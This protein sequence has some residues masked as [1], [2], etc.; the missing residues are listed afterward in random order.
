MKNISS[1]SIKNPIPIILLF[2]LLTIAG[3]LSFISMRINNNPDIDFP[4]VAVTAAPPRRGA[5]RDGDPGHPA[6]R[7]T[8]LAGLSGV[9]HINSHVTDGVSST[10]DR[11]RAG[12]RHRARDQRRPQ[13]HER[14]ARRPAAGHA[15]AVGP[16]HRHHRRR[17][18]HLGGPLLDHDARTDQLVRRQRRQPRPAGHQGRRR[19]QSRRAASIA[20]S[21]SNWI[22]TGWPPT[23]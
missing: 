7:G 16:A 18:D 11:V 4:L 19:G 21:R 17:P 14:P 15:G 5:Q 8:R 12:H 10:I 20:R 1:W 2:V 6:D 22:P 23:A 13:R 9:R 3:L